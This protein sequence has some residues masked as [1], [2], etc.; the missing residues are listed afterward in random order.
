ME[1]Q[2]ERESEPI[3]SKEWM[4]QRTARGGRTAPAPSPKQS[5]AKIERRERREDR[6]EIRE[7]R[8]EKREQR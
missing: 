8:K 5:K 1:R 3:H 4:G 2:S 7:E 6:K